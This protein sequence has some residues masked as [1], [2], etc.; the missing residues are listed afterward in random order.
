MS[1]AP[2]NNILV[3]KGKAD[4]TTIESVK[5]K[6]SEFAIEPIVEMKPRSSYKNVDLHEVW[7]YFTTN[8]RPYEEEVKKAVRRSFPKIKF[9]FSSTDFDGFEWNYYKRLGGRKEY[10]YGTGNVI[11]MHKILAKFIRNK[12]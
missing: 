4:K 12:H 9:Y 7:L 3:L 6:L 10:R 1:Y 11:E 8:G 5:T 2:I